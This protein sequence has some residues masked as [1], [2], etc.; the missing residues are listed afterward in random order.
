MA[1]N[2]GTNSFP[3]ILAAMLNVLNL[4]HKLFRSIMEDLEEL[5]QPMEVSEDDQV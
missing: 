1:E 3:D 5:L 2:S 4:K